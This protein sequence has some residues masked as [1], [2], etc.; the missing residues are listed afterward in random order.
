MAR[1]VKFFFFC[2]IDTVFLM[3]NLLLKFFRFSSFSLLKL[4][5]LPEDLHFCTGVADSF[6]YQQI[7][8]HI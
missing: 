6:L 8:V 4:R 7:N 5:R 1:G 2:F 3:N